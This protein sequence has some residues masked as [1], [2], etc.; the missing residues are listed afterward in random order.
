[1]YTIEYDGAAKGNPGPAGAGALV[2]HP[3]GSVV[4]SGAIVFVRNL[5]PRFLHQSHSFTLLSAIFVFPIHP[6][7]DSYTTG[8]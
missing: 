8:V 1:M 4:R 2:R 6:Q 3:D 7:L 5:F